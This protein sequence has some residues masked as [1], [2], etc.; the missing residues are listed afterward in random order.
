[1]YSHT[2]LAPALEC[3]LALL[4]AVL[5]VR[6]G[7]I[8]LRAHILVH[9]AAERSCLALWPR[10]ALAQM[11]LFYAMESAE[12]RHAGLTGAI[13]QIAV[14]LVV[15]FVL[16]VFARV[17]GACAQSAERAVQYLARLLQSVTS[18]VSRRPAPIAYALAVHAG[19][20]RFQRPPPQL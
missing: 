12:G 8:L 13:V 1:V 17:L 7:Q 20:A 16:S 6:A 4:V 18:F 10:L 9:T 15:A 2:W 19:T 3:S 14:A 11:V 5:L